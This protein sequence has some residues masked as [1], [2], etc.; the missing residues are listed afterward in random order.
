M[1]RESKAP[2]S[3]AADSRASLNFGIG[4]ADTRRREPPTTPPLRM[5]SVNREL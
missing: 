2:G 3:V 1:I 5:R 4:F